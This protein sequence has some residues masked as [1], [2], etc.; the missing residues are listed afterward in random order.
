[1]YEVRGGERQSLRFHLHPT[2]ISTF[3]SLPL[4]VI[5][6]YTYYLPYLLLQITTSN[7]REKING[8]KR[9]R[10]SSHRVEMQLRKWFLLSISHLNYTD[11]R[12]RKEKEEGGCKITFYVC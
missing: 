2:A 7:V 11:G 9:N 4:F 1:M 10:K 3:N 6:T 5:I 8:L 12:K